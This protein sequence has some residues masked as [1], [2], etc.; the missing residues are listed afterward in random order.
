[1]AL[2]AKDGAV[3]KRSLAAKSIWQDV[4]VLGAAYDLCMAAFTV[5]A[6]AFP[7]SQLHLR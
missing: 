7:R 5:A 2:A 6:A 3:L 1:M 4:I